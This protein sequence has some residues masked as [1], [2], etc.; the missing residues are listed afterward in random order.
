MHWYKNTHRSRQYPRLSGDLQLGDTADEG[1]ARTPDIPHEALATLLLPHEGL[2]AQYRWHNQCV[3]DDA[4]GGVGARRPVQRNGH[5][6][7]A[8]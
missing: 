5:D 4:A 6:L 8:G 7:D 2:G 3:R 1:C